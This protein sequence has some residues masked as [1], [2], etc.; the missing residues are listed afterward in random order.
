MIA[1]TQNSFV[2]RVKDGERE[3]AH[4]RWGLIPF[5]ATDLKTGNRMINAQSETAATKPARESD[6]EHHFDF[7]RDVCV[8]CGMTRN[9]YDDT[10]KPP[11]TRKM[12][13]DQREQ[14]AVFDDD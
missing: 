8:K 12:R 1:P 13:P 10:G 3:L 4:L 7:D 11:C 9:Q 2:V 5:W 6:G 14:Q